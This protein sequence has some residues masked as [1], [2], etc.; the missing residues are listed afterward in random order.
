MSDLTQVDVPAAVRER[1][2]AEI[3]NEKVMV[4]SKSYCP[5][6]KA[7]K[8]LLASYGVSP[9]V[10]ELDKETD[11]L[12]AQAALLGITQQRSVPNIFI[13]G[14]HIGGN[15]AIQDLAKQNRLQP[16]LDAAV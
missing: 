2:L 6:C 13:G 12:Q 10:V 5:Y 7:T 14:K 9:T 3:A 11:G 15:D 1:V 8:S 4:Y 16:L